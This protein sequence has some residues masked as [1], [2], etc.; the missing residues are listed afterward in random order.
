MPQMEQLKQLIDCL[1]ILEARCLSNLLSHYSGSQKSK[2]KMWAGL[3]ASE[4]REKVSHFHASHFISGGF[5]A[6]SDVPW[7]VKTQP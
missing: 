4:G 5:L 1:T 6:I 2:I 3:A 7:L